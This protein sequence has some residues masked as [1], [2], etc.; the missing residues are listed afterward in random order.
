MPD[1]VGD[2]C[3]FFLYLLRTFDTGLRWHATVAN[4]DPAMLKKLLFHPL[5]FPGFN[6]SG[7]HLT[8]MAFYDGNL[9]TLKLAAEES[10]QQVATQVRRL[11][12]E[13]A[14]FL[15]LN[16]G[17][18]AVGAQADVLVVHPDALAAWNP[19]ETIQHIWRDEFDHHQ[20][21]NRVPGVV[22]HVLVAGEFAW[23]DGDFTSEFGNR[24][25]GRA[26]RH[27]DHPAE[28]AYTIP[29][30]DKTRAAA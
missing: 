11:T 24:R 16:A 18:L 19:Q 10:L 4:R 13:P 1:P 29:A 23:R 6:D 9:R 7:A 27:R 15:G 22:E 20:M 8:N 21:V 25:Y 28:S 14:E 5:I 2:N 12:A 17:S 30:P 3:D 26:L